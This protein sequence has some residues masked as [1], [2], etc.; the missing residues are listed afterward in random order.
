MYVYVCS[1]SLQ[2]HNAIVYYTQDTDTVT[3]L[4]VLVRGAKVVLGALYNT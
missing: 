1:H 2:Y 3:E 4:G